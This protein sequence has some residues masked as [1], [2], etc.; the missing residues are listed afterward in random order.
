V[1]PLAGV[2]VLLAEDNDVNQEVAREL[3]ADAGCDV[4]V[5]G[6]GAAAVRSVEASPRGRPYDVVLMDC[7]M[8]E[9]DGFQAARRIRERESEG[10][11]SGS[12][13]PIIALTA[14]AVEGDRQRCLDAGMD[15]YVTKPID[16]ELLIRAIGTLINRDGNPSSVTAS[17]AAAAAAEPSEPVAP[18]VAAAMSIFPDAGGRPIDVESLLRRCQGKAALAERLL[19]KFEQQMESQVGELRAAME[20]RERESVARLAHALKGAAANMS[21]DP[22][23]EAAGELERQA[24]A[25]EFDAALATMES[26]AA[27]AHECS[28]FI[29]AAIERVGEKPSQLPG[30]VAAAAA[31]SLL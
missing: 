22:L 17:A 26:L 8:P 19:A 29:P 6:D 7:Q 9:L 27:R 4:V 2:R 14:N 10:E 16:P 23:R 1:R 18:P 20:R 28:Q 12:R 31:D 25:A 3:L 15:D 5:V 30:A 11:S 21:A 24:V 13:L